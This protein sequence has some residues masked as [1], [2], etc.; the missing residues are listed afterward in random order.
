MSNKAAKKASN[1]TT[2][3]VRDVES[4][5]AAETML[6]DMI[7]IVLD[8]IKAAPD[9][10]QKLGES[11][12]GECIDRIRRRC[13]NTV[14][15]CVRYIATQGFARIRASV[16]SVAI[17]DGIKAVLTLNKH[18]P[19]RHELIDAQGMGVYI[20]LADANAF[21]GGAYDA[22]P[23]PDQ[24]AL[25]LNEVERIGRDSK[26]VDGDDLDKAA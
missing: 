6:G 8:E 14:E 21:G 18:D 3:T 23:D 25:A 5:V 13:E 11:E 12:Q 26:N 19:N 2:E 4:E 20:V 9:V 24:A 15:D 7:A 17:K 1:E 16:E 22:K 10:W